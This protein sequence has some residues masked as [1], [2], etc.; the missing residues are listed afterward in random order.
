[1]KEAQRQLEKSTTQSKDMK[2]RMLNERIATI[3]KFVRAREAFGSGDTN[4]MVTLCDQL[5]NQPGADEAIRLG[6]VFAQLVEFFNSARQFQQAYTY[7]EKMRKKNIIITPYL[8]P[9][10]VEQVYSAVG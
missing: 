8:D 2:M 6:D 1:M 3:E 7:I 4:T 5:I 9:S 10:L